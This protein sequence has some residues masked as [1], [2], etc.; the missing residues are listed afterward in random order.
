MSGKEEKKTTLFT[1]IAKAIA[2]PY[3]R[4]QQDTQAARMAGLTTDSRVRSDRMT[5]TITKSK[6]PE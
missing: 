2:T 6:L 3:E 4:T 1:R 5:S